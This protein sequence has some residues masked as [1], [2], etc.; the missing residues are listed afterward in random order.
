[1]QLSV[2][3]WN[4]WYREKADNILA[5]L[6]ASNADIVCLQE[7]TTDSSTNPGVN[8]PKLIRSLGYKGYYEQT[9]DRPAD[10]CY[11]MG[12]AL[13]SRFPIR[14][15]RTCLLAEESPGQETRLYIEAEV[16]APDGTLYVGTT[17]LSWRPEGAMEEANQLLEY[18]SIRK[19]RLIF[20]GDLNVPS[21]SKLLSAIEGEFLNATAGKP[22]PTWPTK[23][24]R[25]HGVTIE[26][27]DRQLDY[28]FTSKDINVVS[29][30][31]IDSPHSDHLPLL[32]VIDI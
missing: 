31:T 16:A 15:S 24:Y 21:G 10:P 5:Q 23:P 1:M 20:T 12:N 2:L 7:I 18:L 14:P 22:T 29:T 26:H 32:A 28:I 13:F 30:A 4:V 3:Q 27:L 25:Y 19:E 17:H 11:K 9:L 6:R 8:I